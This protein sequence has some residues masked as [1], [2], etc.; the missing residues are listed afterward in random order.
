M[1]RS[2]NLADLNIDAVEVTN[3]GDESVTVINK[4]GFAIEKIVIDAQHRTGCAGSDRR[5]SR[6][7][8]IKSVV[9]CARFA[10]EE[11]AQSKMAGQASFGGVPEIAVGF[12]SIA[13]VAFELLDAGNFP[14]GSHLVFR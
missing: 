8:E 3:H 11:T 13:P 6:N 12:G 9:W 7:R 4:D 2:H 10:V 1:S 5:S 14:L